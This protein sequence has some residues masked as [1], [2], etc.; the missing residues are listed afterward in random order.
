MTFLADVGHIFAR[1]LRATIRMPTFMIMSIIQ[2]LMWIM[3]FG[4]LFQI[5]RKVPGFGTGSYLEFLTPGI[6]VMTAL[7]GS[8]YSGLVIL[9]ELDRGIIDRLIVTP[10]D[11][12]AVILARGLLAG[13]IASVQGIIII[14][15]A[16]VLGARPHGVAAT[17][18]AL[19]AASLLATSIAGCSCALAFVMRRQESFLALVNFILLPMS[20]L[21]N[22]MMQK[23]LMPR[24]MRAAAIANPV[25]WAVTI[26]RS[27][28]D[29]GHFPVTHSYLVFLSG[30]CVASMVVG[31]IAIN[32]YRRSL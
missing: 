25:D 16:S 6:V 17:A 14:L 26:A 24:W 9:S 4:Q 12:R 29:S 28:F 13:C 21:S 3:L 10:A 1:Y 23:N 32:Q 18:I 27:G 5:M 22:M 2:P 31:T 15:A 11:C 30:F 7:F 8:G 20:F 19:A